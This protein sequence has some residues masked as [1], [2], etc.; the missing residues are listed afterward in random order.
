MKHPVSRFRKRSIFQAIF[1]P[2]IFI[3]VLQ[4]GLFY[5]MAVYGGV[6][7]SLN[8]NEADILR[9]RLVNRKT[10]LKGEFTG[11]WSNLTLCID[12]LG[13]LY[14]SYQAELGAK[15]FP[16]NYDA[17]VRFLADSS[18][19]LIRA[20]RSNQVNGV[21]LLLNDRAQYAAPQDGEVLQETGLC[22]R[23]LDLTNRH[24][25]REDLLVERCPSAVADQLG[26]SLDSWWEARYTFEPGN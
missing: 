18:N 21:F 7:R 6:E 5:L 13:L 20:L 3:M 14:R 4:S 9:E 19:L 23:D 26:C 1:V 10:E 2:L 8:Q 16:G 22:I 11:N 17:K 25:G 15:P 24:T 12:Q